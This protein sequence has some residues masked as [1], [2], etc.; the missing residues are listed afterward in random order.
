MVVAVRLRG[1]NITRARG[2]WYVYPRG[3]GDALIKGFAGSRDELLKKLAEPDLIQSYNR[4]RLRQRL[5]AS[6]PME[7][8]GGFIHWFT[9]GAIDDA[10]KGEIDGYPKWWR[11]ADSTRQDYVEAFD[12]LRPE[13]DIS[14]AEITQPA[15]YEVRDECAHKKWPRFADQMIAALSSMFRQAVKRGKMPFNPC[16]GMDKAHEADPN[17]NREWLSVEWKFASEN[18]PLEVLIP[19]MTA[20]Y[21]GLRGQTIVKLNRS[22]FEDHPLTGKAVRYAARKNRMTV[23]LPVMP[24][25]LRFMADLKVQRADGLLAVRDDGSPWASEKEM[26]TRVS[27]WLRDQERKGLIGADTTLHGLRVSYAAWWKRN[28]ASD[29]EVAALIGDR[30]LRMG[31]HYTRHVEAEVSVMRAFDR[32]KNSE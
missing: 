16:L 5:A 29:S 14:L 31:T 6:F 19:M 13:F 28:G 18:A 4:P 25:Y 24:E 21:I 20:R 30:S 17:A 1:L 9:C 32:L 26:Q 12:Y 3:G 23:F 11:L 22:Q 27:H 8:L 7:T 2:R 15:L 10:E